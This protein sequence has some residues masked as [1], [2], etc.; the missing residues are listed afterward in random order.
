MDRD[1]PAQRPRGDLEPAPEVQHVVSIFGSATRGGSWEPPDRLEVFSLFGSVELDFRD[2]AVL[3]LTTV[4][5]FSLFGSV[6]ITVGED[7]QVDA[8][9]TGIF[10]AFYQGQPKGGRGWVREVTGRL[11]GE[12]ERAP[13][14]DP[15]VVRV[16][17]LA[18]FGNVGVRVRS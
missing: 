9:G 7:V 14:D 13:D 8:D 2:A 5:C 17:G 18:L 15:A 12:R 11:R 16:R 3:D 4:S 6:S 1:V 10:G